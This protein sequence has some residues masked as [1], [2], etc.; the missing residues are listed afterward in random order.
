MAVVNNSINDPF[1]FQLKIGIG[2]IRDSLTKVRVIN[3]MLNVMSR[4]IREGEICYHGYKTFGTLLYKKGKNGFNDFSPLSM[5]YILGDVR[6]S[7]L[8]VSVIR[9]ILN[10]I[11]IHGNNIELCYYGCKA[12]EIILQNN[13]NQMC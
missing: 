10:S 12:L 2:D 8:K 5:R 7:S 1:I 6:D 9:V 11:N 3:I 4:Y 13:S